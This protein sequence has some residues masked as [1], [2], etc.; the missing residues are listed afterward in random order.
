M[1]EKTS[2]RKPTTERKPTPKEIKKALDEI[3]SAA[4]AAR[5]TIGRNKV[6]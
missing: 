2:E 6:R 5:N 3:R 1:T 4:N